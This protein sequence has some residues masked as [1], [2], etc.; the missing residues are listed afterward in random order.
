MGGT[1]FVGKA[2]VSKLCSQGHEL[3]LFT[4]GRNPVPSNVEHL[5]GDRT[6]KKDL[7][8]LKDRSFDVIVDSSGRKLEDT[9]SILEYTSSP[10]FR[11]LYVSSAGVY[12]DSNLIPVDEKS[13]L[14]PHSRHSGKADT[15]N[16]LIKESIPF[17]S[18]RPTYIYGPGNYN[19]IERWFFDRIIHDQPIPI[20]SNGNTI[21]QLGH[22][23]DLAEAM[24]LCLK[25]ECAKNRIYN[26][27]GKQG[28]TFN[29]LVA[30]AA[31]ACGKKPENVRT[32]Y[33][34]PS[35]LDSKARK[36]FPL[37]IG[38]FFTDIS[39]LEQDLNWKPNFDL[40]NGLLDS[41]K[42]DYV[43]NPSNNPDFSKDNDLIS[44]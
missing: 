13:E 2:L 1:R 4:R 16:W 17:T 37:R 22:V 39:R 3:T 9:R 29:G 27:S 15:E 11:L 38:H 25:Y 32:F 8:I 18:F 35:Y 24:S 36:S 28:I 43:L 31:I 34:D 23:D 10:N 21:T 26:C 20:P 5:L 19:P 40:T 42:R 14:D 33:F 12:A 30:C 41:F 6:S 7:T 44:V